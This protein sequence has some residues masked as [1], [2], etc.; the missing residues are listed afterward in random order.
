MADKKINK[1]NNPNIIDSVK[2]STI[3]KELGQLILTH[4]FRQV[5]DLPKL[6][7]KLISAR[8]ILEC[9]KNIISEYGFE[10]NI[11]TN[12]MNYYEGEK[13]LKKR[14]NKYYID[15]IPSII[16]VYNKELFCIVDE[17]QSVELDF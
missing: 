14:E 5:F 1:H 16:D 11:I 4:D 9:I 7:N 3:N 6:K 17:L 12:T 13:R 15:L 8:T 2:Y 10:I